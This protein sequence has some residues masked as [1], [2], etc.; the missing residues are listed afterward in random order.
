MEG[1]AGGHGPLG[2]APLHLDYRLRVVIEAEAGLTAEG[3]ATATVDVVGQVL[4]RGPAPGHL[5]DGRQGRQPGLGLRQLRRAGL[6]RV[7]LAVAHEGLGRRLLCIFHA[8][9]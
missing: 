4:H 8:H 9:S 3:C 5:A 7:G 1:M 6:T 2:A